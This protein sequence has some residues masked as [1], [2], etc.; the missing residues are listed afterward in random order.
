MIIIIFFLKP[1]YTVIEQEPPREKFSS[2]QCF[3]CIPIPNETQWVKDSYRV[4]FGEQLTIQK[5]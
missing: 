4:H 1:G 5:R 2:R 3:S